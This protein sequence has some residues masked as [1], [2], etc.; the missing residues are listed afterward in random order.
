M[1][2]AQEWHYHQH[3]KRKAKLII[4]MLDP[5]LLVAATEATELLHMAIK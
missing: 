1:R 4:G 5:S 3:P 2:V